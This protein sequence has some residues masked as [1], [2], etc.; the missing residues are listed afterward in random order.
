M[1][2]FGF[3]YYMYLIFLTWSFVSH[4][5]LNI[6]LFFFIKILLKSVTKL[7][8]IIKY[9]LILHRFRLVKK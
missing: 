4:E 3:A 7:I 5:W 1:F 9:Y 2:Q 6:L 8:I